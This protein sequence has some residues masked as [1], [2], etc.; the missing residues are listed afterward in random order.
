MWIC[1][2]ACGFVN[3]KKDFL[4]RELEG[5]EKGLWCFGHPQISHCWFLSVAVKSRN[6]FFYCIDSLHKIKHNQVFLQEQRPMMSVRCRHLYRPKVD[7]IL[8]IHS[9]QNFCGLMSLLGFTLSYL[10][11]MLCHFFLWITV[12]LNYACSWFWRQSRTVYV[13]CLATRLWIQPPCHLVESE[14]V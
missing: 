8:K 3:R 13:A 5:S 1:L 2:F 14:V 9:F 7:S 6:S 12:V 10:Q 11:S 4:M